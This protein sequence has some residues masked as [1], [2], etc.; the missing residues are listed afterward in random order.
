MS[1]GNTPSEDVGFSR[2]PGLHKLEKDSK[3]HVETSK[4][5]RPNTLNF[6]SLIPGGREN[7]LNQ[8]HTKYS[9]ASAARNSLQKVIQSTDVRSPPVTP[10]TLSTCATKRP[11]FLPIPS[12][13]SSSSNFHPDVH[14]H[15]GAFFSGQNK[16]IT[17][18]V[19]Y[20][21]VLSVK[22]GRLIRPNVVGSSNLKNDWCFQVCHSFVRHRR[23]SYCYRANSRKFIKWSPSN[24]QLCSFPCFDKRRIIHKRFFIPKYSICWDHHENIF[25]HCSCIPVYHG[26]RVHQTLSSLS[27]VHRCHSY[28][29][30]KNTRCT[31]AKVWNRCTHLCV[32]DSG[33]IN[34]SV[35]NRNFGE[36]TGS[37]VFDSYKL[38]DVHDVLIK[39]SKKLS[40]TID[41]ETEKSTSPTTIQNMTSG[42]T[43]PIDI[44]NANRGYQLRVDPLLTRTCVNEDY[45]NSEQLQLL[46]KSPQSETISNEGEIWPP[47]VVSIHPELVL[48]YN[49][50]AGLLVSL[51]ENKSTCDKDAS[52][53]NIDFAH[54]ISHPVDSDVPMVPVTKSE[55][56]TQLS[57]IPPG[58]TLALTRNLHIHVHPTDL[59]C[60]LKLSAWCFASRGFYQYG[61]EEIVILLRRRPDEKLPPLDIFYQYWLI[62]QALVSRAQKEIKSDISFELFSS[63]TYNKPFGSAPFRSHDCFFEKLYFANGRCSNSTETTSFNVNTNSRPFSKTSSNIDDCNNPYGFVFFH[64]THQCLTGLHIP[65]PPF[66]IALLVHIQEAPWA[67]RLPSRILLNLGKVSHY[68]PTT[69]LSDRDREILFNCKVD[70]AS[71]LQLFTNI[72]PFIYPDF[73]TALPKQKPV[74][75]PELL[76]HI[77]GFFAH[78]NMIKNDR[79]SGDTNS[80]NITEE[81][82]L[83][84]L[85]PLS[86]RAV[87]MRFLDTVPVESMTFALSADCNPISDSHLVCS[88]SQ[89]KY[90]MSMNSHTDLDSSNDDANEKTASS[91]NYF[92][93]SNCSKNY[94]TGAIS[95][96]NTKPKV[97]GV[98]FVAFSGRASCCSA[99]IVEDGVYITLTDSKCHQLI[100]SLKTGSDLSIEIRSD[101]QSTGIEHTGS[102]DSSVIRDQNVASSIHIKWFKVFDSFL[103]SASFS[104]SVTSPNY[105]SSVGVLDLEPINTFLVPLHYQ[106]YHWMYL[107]ENNL[108]NGVDRFSSLS[109]AGSPHLRLAW[110]RFHIFNV[111]EMETISARLQKPLTFGHL[112]N[113]VAQCVT[114]A[115]EPYLIQLRSDGR[116][117]ITLHIELQSPD[118][119]GYRMS[120]SCHEA[121][122]LQN[123]SRSKD[124]SKD[125]SHQS[126]EHSDEMYADALD[127]F[128]L[129]VLSSWINRLKISNPDKVNRLYPL[130]SPDDSRH[131]EEI[132]QMEFDLCI[133][134]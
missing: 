116:T 127:D 60:C 98:S 29:R 90:T 12:Q 80:S 34:K 71:F 99:V 15:S 27:L 66:L 31:C 22:S 102:T 95:I 46:A 18:T 101:N 56:H 121:Y 113:E 9:S 100:N 59:K 82:I 75:M 104:G 21:S 107:D 111:T 112:A 67:Y 38:H 106:L 14:Q 48:Q 96:E 126:K 69:L 120:A 91:L 123:Q 35:A 26:R 85:V 25:N 43:I 125:F 11:S 72:T 87:L 50:P 45:P 133:L 44:S 78:L 117:Q 88:Q 58:I 70:G 3:R 118:Q 40:G 108:S 129:P 105:P 24:M 109:T 36:A 93:D 33:Q 94:D 55:C 30:C 84:L 134:D 10:V 63:A 74:L 124:D 13:G 20:T 132:I 32:K 61:Q 119:V 130:V 16:R 2:V 115:I 81:V 23:L 128:L 4:K 28:S 6:T 5:H 37:P 110:I 39:S 131:G 73:M 17:P 122:T 7:S 54:D 62:Y 47:L 57:S 92:I 64:P 83:E 19:K 86:S 52:Q 51:L 77:N 8:K 68:Y 114:K 65:D 76:L 1:G 53:S 97:T 89:K 49:P 41:C 103:S 42:F 79:S